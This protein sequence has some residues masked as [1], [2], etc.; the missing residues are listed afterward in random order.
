VCVSAN[1]PMC[2]R[3]QQGAQAASNDR[4]IINDENPH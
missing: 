1:G 2:P 4:V 3:R